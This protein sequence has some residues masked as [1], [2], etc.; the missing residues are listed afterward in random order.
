VRN[1]HFWNLNLVPHDFFLLV[2]IFLAAT[3]T[4]YRD[5][6]WEHWKG[7]KRIGLSEQDFVLVSGIPSVMKAAILTDDHP[8]I[9][10]EVFQRVT[11][12]KVV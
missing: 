1:E 3:L 5:L 7:G 6:V 8:E 4:T 2:G 10:S 9:V 11:S 12:L